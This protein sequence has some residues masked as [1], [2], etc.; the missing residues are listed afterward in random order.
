MG[1]ALALTFRRQAQESPAW[2]LLRSPLAPVI[3]SCLATI[4]NAERR[5]ITGTE[6]IEELNELLDELRDGEFDLPRTASAYIN[7]WVKDG[8]LVRRSPRGEK[9]E[10][11][12]LSR[13]AMDGL[14]YV[15]KL[16][17]PRK[18]ATRSRL[19]TVMD[20]LS[21]LSMKTDP[22]ETQVLARLEEEKQRI[23]RRIE[24]VKEKGVDVISDDEAVE[25]A[26]NILSLVTDIPSDFAR[27]R[28]ATE[29][30]DQQLR[31]QLVRNEV[32]ASEVLENIFRG[33]DLIQDSE[34]GKSFSSFYEL[35]FDREQSA[36]L[37]Q[38]LAEL[39]ER[40]FV[41]GLTLEERERLRWIMRDLEGHADEVHTA[42]IQLSR[43][44]RRFVQSREA[45]SHQEL[46]QRISAAQSKALEVGKV[47]NPSTQLDVEIELTGRQF[48]S[49]STWRLKDPA[50]TRIEGDM[51]IAQIGT[52][53]IEDLRKRVRESEID[54]EE[55][56]SN[57]S[58]VVATQGQA[59][60]GDVLA[61]YPATQGL[62][63]V[64]GLLTLG[65][66]AQAEQLGSERVSWIVQAPSDQPYGAN[67]EIMR[68][69]QIPLFV[70]TPQSV[71]DN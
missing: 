44:L 18:S 36:V 60:I 8:Y 63:S 10:F 15:H 24:S 42:L 61:V 23:E 37:D 55:L 35:L 31:E 68:A 52:E 64:V 6:L 46:A 20:Q 66:Q 5:Q 16:A 33:V 45:E 69:A 17:A 49:V 47:I 25:Q 65:L 3:A 34:E 26:E 9:E 21:N 54:W 28:A 62:A 43:S 48:S 50:E 1:I 12:E 14:D 22:D 57:V 27:V 2:S 13:A 29:D 19:A 56:S 41:D 58:A 4:F 71:K 40:S 70:F 11:Y 30:L 32:S 51:E 7:E 67:R 38:Q 39:V 59:S 53:S